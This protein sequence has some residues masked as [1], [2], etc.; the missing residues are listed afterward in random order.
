MWHG[1]QS[2]LLIDLYLPS[3]VCVCVFTALYRM[4]LGH[5]ITT[6]HVRTAC[7]KGQQRCDEAAALT[8]EPGDI[9]QSH[10]RTVKIN[11]VFSW[12][13]GV[14]HANGANVCER[15]VCGHHWIGGWI[16]WSRGRVGN[17]E[18]WVKDENKERPGDIKSGGL[19]YIDP[20]LSLAFEDS[21]CLLTQTVM[22]KYQNICWISICSHLHGSKNSKFMNNKYFLD[23]S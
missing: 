4:P 22:N 16:W 11:A 2:R 19:I 5:F 8:S 23:Q 9:C 13:K 21:D 6:Q 15:D 14:A 12:G 18:G 3:N 20:L 1:S 10:T 7:C 17:T